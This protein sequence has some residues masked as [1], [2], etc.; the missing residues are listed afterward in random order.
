MLEF[1]RKLFHFFSLLSLALFVLFL[2]FW[3]NVLFFSVA[4]V[5]NYLLVKRQKK[6]LGLLSPLIYALERERNL[7]RPGIQSLYALLGIFI[8]YLLFGEGSLYGIL[9]LAVGDAFSGLVG[10][11]MGKHPLPYNPRK[12][13]EGSLAFFI[14]S[15]LALLPFTDMYTALFVSLTCA[16]AESLPL[17]FDDN[18]Y[19]PLL[20]SSLMFLAGC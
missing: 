4:I 19:I 2:P 3:A 13:A 11:Y 20:A 16:L 18:F 5:I 7:S 8:S 10:Y 15:F 17:P 6:L 9:V 14:S 12:T 1:R